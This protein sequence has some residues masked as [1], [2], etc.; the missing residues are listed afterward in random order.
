M[1][2]AQ[3]KNKLDLLNGNFRVNKGVC[4]S[5][6][7]GIVLIWRMNSWSYLSVLYTE[8]VI[9]ADGEMKASRALKEAA[10]VMS[11]SP[12]ALQLRYM[13]TLTEIATERNSTIV[14]PLPIDL[15]SNF[16]RRWPHM[17]ITSINMFKYLCTDITAICHLLKHSLLYRKKIFCLYCWWFELCIK[18]LNVSY[19]LMKNMFNKHWIVQN[20]LL[21]YIIKSIKYYNQVLLLYSDRSFL[22]YFICIKVIF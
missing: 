9:A 6:W 2:Q 10:D 13:Q 14:F 18:Y 16:M 5:L 8:Q 20:V 21:Y 19:T 3:W 11:E 22:D 12:A 7:I 15:I 4:Q 1:A 17:K